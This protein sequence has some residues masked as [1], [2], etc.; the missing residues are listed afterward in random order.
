M[1]R[2]GMDRALA[3]ID[4]SYVSTHFPHLKAD[5]KKLFDRFADC[6]MEHQRANTPVYRRFV[7]FQYLPIEAFKRADVASFPPKEAEAVFKSSGT[8]TSD[9]RST[10]YIKSLAVYRRSV[11][12]H[13]KIVFGR[14]PFTIIACM[15]VGSGAFESSSLVTM[16]QMLIEELGTP[17]SSFVRVDLDALDVA[18]RSAKEFEAP[19][20]LFGLAFG[21][22]DIVDAGGLQ[23]APDSIVL[24]TGGMKVHRREI[25]RTELHEKLSRGFG[26]SQDR[27]RSEYGMCELLSQFYMREDGL[28]YPPPWVQFRVFDPYVPERELDEGELGALAVLDLAN[29]YSVSSILTQDSAIR[30]GEGFDLVGRLTG[31][32]LRGCNYLL[33]NVR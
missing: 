26:V 22:L 1:V 32:E 29:M 19:M 2:Q 33:E 10:H 24:E 14:G 8:A 9:N 23:L 25:G 20:I 28:F 30:I 4:V 17:V 18:V 13:F 21:L 31:A 7:D 3:P 11:L 15:P 12:A 5:D 27:I 16:A 6:V